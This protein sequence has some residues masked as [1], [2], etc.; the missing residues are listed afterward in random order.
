MGVG[1]GRG[2]GGGLAAF[3]REG[4]CGWPGGVFGLGFGFG[5]SLS[6]GVL[7]CVSWNF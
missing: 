4:G 5:F 1:V 7:L 3:A 2:T 6:E